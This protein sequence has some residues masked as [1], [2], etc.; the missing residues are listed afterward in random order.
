MVAG[1]T[2]T[3]TATV[4]N[5][6]TSAGVTWTATTGSVASSG[7]YTAPMPVVTETATVTATSKADPT[8]SASVSVPLTST[9]S[10]PISLN[11]I[12][13]ATIALGIG[14]S[15]SFTDSV[16]N[17]PSNS[18]VSWTIGSGPGSLTAS[19]TTGVAY[20]ARTSAVSATTT[21]TLTA[22]SIKDPTKST[23]ATTTLNPISVG[24]TPTNAVMTGG[25]TQGFAAGVANDGTNAGVTWT[26]TGGGSFSAIA[27]LS[28]ASTIYT[29]ASPVTAATATITATSKADPTKSG[30]VTVTLTPISLNPI[31]PVAATL[32]TS[33]SRRS[34]IRST[35]MDQ[36]R[37]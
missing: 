10:N 21:V 13:P 24:V 18:G 27:T 23:T 14:G 4:A 25:A 16:V 26:V 6:A 29:A 31:S 19:S 28:G 17:D 1:A 3:F 35:M 37:A 2:Q 33:G 20:N 22:T 5:D 12:S 36:T 15:Q 7:V 9:I 32:G 8:K 34:R 30:S 11:P